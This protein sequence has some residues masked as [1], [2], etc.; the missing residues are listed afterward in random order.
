M[1]DQPE[2][3]DDGR[4]ERAVRALLKRSLAAD[5]ENAP[6]LLAGVQRRIRLRSRGKFF[7]DGWSTTQ[8][9][10]SYVLIGITTL[11]LVVLAYW[12]LSPIGMR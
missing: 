1:S 10:A 12:M 11:L 8:T 7:A 2:P 4:D 9:R 6:D 3:A 5:E